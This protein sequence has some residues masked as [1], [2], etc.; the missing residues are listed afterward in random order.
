MVDNIPCIQEKSL[1]S[2]DVYSIYWAFTWY[3]YVKSETLLYFIKYLQPNAARN[4]IIILDLL[5]R[6]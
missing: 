3:F 1:F 2:Y 6:K 5:V 4:F